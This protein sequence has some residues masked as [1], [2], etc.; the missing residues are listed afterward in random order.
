MCFFLNACAGTYTRIILTNFSGVKPTY[1]D[2]FCMIWVLNM[3]YD[4]FSSP[5]YSML[6]C[7]SQWQSLFVFWMFFKL[8]HDVPSIVCFAQRFLKLFTFFFQVFQVFPMF[9]MGFPRFPRRFQGVFIPEK[10]NWP[11]R[12]GRGLLPRLRLGAERRAY[13]SMIHIYIYIC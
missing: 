9:C 8:S 11:S 12:W 5:L 13:A 7:S 4:F 6:S 2:W 1:Y 3:S 10:R